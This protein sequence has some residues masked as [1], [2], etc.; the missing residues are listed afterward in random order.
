MA[1]CAETCSALWEETATP[2]SLMGGAGSH[3]GS[4]WQVPSV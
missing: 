1:E 2:G 3:D 4:V